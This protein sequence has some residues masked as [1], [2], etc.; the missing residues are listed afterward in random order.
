MRNAIHW[1]GHIA[2]VGERM[3]DRFKV[4]LKWG[5]LYFSKKRLKKNERKKEKEEGLIKMVIFYRPI[6]DLQNVN[7]SREICRGG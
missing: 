6:H 4:A 5:K 1:A 2:S 7:T 3:E